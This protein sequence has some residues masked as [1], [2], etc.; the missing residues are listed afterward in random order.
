MS[1]QMWFLTKCRIL[2]VVSHLIIYLIVKAINV[3]FN[4]SIAFFPTSFTCKKYWWNG[5]YSWYI[6]KEVMLLEDYVFRIVNFGLVAI[7]LYMLLYF[8]SMCFVI[9]YW[10]YG[11]NN[12]SCP[13]AIFF[14]PT[15]S[16]CFSARLYHY[17]SIFKTL[18]VLNLLTVLREQM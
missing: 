4:V 18:N 13:E 2:N 1:N 7:W 10:H 8:S 5:L 11:L 15:E 16:R 12:A 9:N 3:L 14:V 17:T 6:E